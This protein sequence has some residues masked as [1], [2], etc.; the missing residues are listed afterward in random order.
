MWG[1][2]MESRSCRN[3]LKHLCPLQELV[4]REKKKVHGE[5]GG[6]GEWGG[7]KLI[8]ERL[9]A[10]IST[11]SPSQPLPPIFPPKPKSACN[12]SQWVPGTINQ[13]F[14]TT[15]SPGI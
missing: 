7:M 6:G 11:P 3:I 1:V 12:Q 2:A 8:P 14:A 15:Y 4:E 13:C 10:S 5:R 9:I